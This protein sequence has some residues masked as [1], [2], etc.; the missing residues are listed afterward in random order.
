MKPRRAKA[1]KAELAR[2]AKL[3]EMPCIACIIGRHD[4]INGMCGKHEI[5]HLTSG[6]R[7]LGNEKTIPLGAWHHQ[8]IIL[9]GKTGREMVKIFGPSF[10]KTP[11][12]FEAYFGS[13]EFLLME[14]NKLLGIRIEGHD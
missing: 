8:G 6:G 7:R 13:E 10:G 5:H 9:R 4:L 2:Y 3:K 14:T 11:R 1:T 12:Q